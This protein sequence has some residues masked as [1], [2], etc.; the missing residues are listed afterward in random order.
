MTESF[1]SNIVKQRSSRHWRDI[2]D[3]PSTCASNFSFGQQGDTFT[4][5]QCDTSSGQQGNVFTKKQGGTS[6]K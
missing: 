1:V 4:Q 2:E 5:Q 3:W 6:I